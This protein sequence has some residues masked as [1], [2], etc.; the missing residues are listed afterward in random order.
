[1]MSQVTGEVP[2]EFFAPMDA[3]AAVMMVLVAVS[4]MIAAVGLVNLLTIGVVQRRRSWDCCAR[5]VCP[6]A[7]CDGWCCSKPRTSR[8]RRL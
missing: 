3:F 5:S 1:M 2:E 7:R 6:T 4:A 8:S